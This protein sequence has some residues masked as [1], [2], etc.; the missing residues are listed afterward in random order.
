MKLTT[1]ITTLV[2]LCLSIFNFQANAADALEKSSTDITIEKSAPININTADEDTLIKLPGIGMKKAKAIV[3]YR[4][5]NGSFESAE[6][7]INVKGIG[8]K[9]M[10]KLALQITV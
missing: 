4:Q 7:L 3:E 5:R 8:E 1:W 10:A 6:E 9:L 2:F